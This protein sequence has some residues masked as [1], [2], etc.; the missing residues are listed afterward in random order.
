MLCIIFLARAVVQVNFCPSATHLYRSYNQLFNAGLS[1]VL[2]QRVAASTA[3]VVAVIN[4][5][6]FSQSWLAYF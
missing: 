1:S 2:V 6:V 5:R 3:A 4:A